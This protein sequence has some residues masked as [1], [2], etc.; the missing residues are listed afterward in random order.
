MAYRFKIS[1]V[2]NIGESKI[3]PEIF[4]IAAV[5]PDKPATPP[6]ITLVT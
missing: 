5:L 6:T 4:V 3:S 2:N 1:A